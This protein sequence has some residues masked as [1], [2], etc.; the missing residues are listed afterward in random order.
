MEAA[1]FSRDGKTIAFAEGGEFNNATGKAYLYDA[2]T[3]KKRLDLPGHYGGVA[4]VA[5]S[6]DGKRL[7][8]GGRDTMVRVW[9]VSGG[10]KIAEFGKSRGVQSRDWIH[11]VAWSTDGQWIAAADMGGFVHVYQLSK[12]P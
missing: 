6:P 3:G 4:A 2:Q 9:Q 10:K 1:D 12:Q 8:T 5:F 11:A 7:A